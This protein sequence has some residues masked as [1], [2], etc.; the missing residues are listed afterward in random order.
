MKDNTEMIEDERD[1][2]KSEVLSTSTKDNTEIIEEEM[3]NSKSEVLNPSTDSTIKST[4]IYWYDISNNN[5]NQ[6]TRLNIKWN[7]VPSLDKSIICWTFPFYGDDAIKFQIYSIDFLDV[8]EVKKEEVFTK[9]ATTLEKL[10]ESYESEEKNAVDL[11]YN[12][13]VSGATY[14]LVST[15]VS[16]LTHYIIF[17]QCMILNNA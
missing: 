9:D 4:G 11:L 12:L 16:L 15:K 7:I 10:L 17:I 6:T 8:S 14:N 1:D 13:F 2:S 5:R 3:D